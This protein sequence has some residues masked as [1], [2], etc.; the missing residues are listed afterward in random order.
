MAENY[1]SSPSDSNLKDLKTPSRKRPMLDS[2]N[3]FVT[4]EPKRSQMQTTLTIPPSPYLE[5]LGT[6]TG[7]QLSIYRIAIRPTGAILP[8]VYNWLTLHFES[9]WCCRLV[10]WLLLSKFWTYAKVKTQIWYQMAAVLYSHV[11]CMLPRHF[12]IQNF[13][14]RFLFEAPSWQIF[15]CDCRG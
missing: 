10:H 1:T 14:I 4:P 5:R 13:G 9:F 15:S 8:T 6:G 3:S 7:Q 11:V 2:T 12:V